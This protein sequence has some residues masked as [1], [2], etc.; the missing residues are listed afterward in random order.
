MG[1]VA[2]PAGIRKILGAA[3]LLGVAL[4]V[5]STA[6]HAERGSGLYLAADL[7]MASSSTSDLKSGGTRGKTDFGSALGY[8]AAV[9]FGWGPLRMEG[10][11]SWRETDIDS[12]EYTRFSVAGQ[13]LPQ[14]VVRDINNAV[15]LKG[16]RATLSLMANAWYDLDVGIGFTPYFGGGLGI[17]YV[18]YE[19]DRP[20]DLSRFEPEVVSAAR[21]IGGDD[22]DWVLAYQIG[23][24]VAYRLME[25]LVVQVGYRYMGA[26]DPKLTSLS[27]S[28]AKSEAGNHVF[29]AGIRIG[30]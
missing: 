16:S 11:A 20:R 9:G 15:D 27:D 5:F 25:S 26:G 13:D 3:T 1:N 7:G 6:A 8:S 22:G 24:G 19:I 14:D 17:Q 10:E 4:L 28:S 29:R 23:G 30:F 18:R 12:I 21:T 2:G